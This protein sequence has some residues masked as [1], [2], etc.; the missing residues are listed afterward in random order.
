MNARRLMLPIASVRRE[1]EDAESR[2]ELEKTRL[3]NQLG[4]KP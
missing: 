4:F 2:V 3:A 1:R